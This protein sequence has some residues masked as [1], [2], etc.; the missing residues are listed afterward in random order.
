MTTKRRKIKSAA[1]F[2]AMRNG[3]SLHLEYYQSGPRWRMSTGPYVTNEVARE[4]IA[5]C[6]QIIGVGDSLFGRALS[7]TWRY[8]SKENTQ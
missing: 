5:D 1:V 6:K 3:A 4:V 8:Y 2:R 7:Q